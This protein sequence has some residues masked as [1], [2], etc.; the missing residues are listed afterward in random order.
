MLYPTRSSAATYER[1][2]P[3]LAR[4][5]HALSHEVADNGR[6]RVGF[7]PVS[8]WDIAGV[9]RVARQIRWIITAPRFLAYPPT[10]DFPPLPVL[11]GD[12]LWLEVAGNKLHVLRLPNEHETL[13]TGRHVADAEDRLE[14][15]QIEHESVSQQ[16]RDAHR[17]RRAT[18]ELNSRKKPLNADVTS[19]KARL[20]TLRRFQM[21]LSS[22]VA[23][24][25]NILRCPTCGKQADPRREFEGGP[26]HRFS[27]TC[28]ECS[29]TWGTVACPR[30]RGWIPT[31]L[32]ASRSWIGQ[33]RGPGWLDKFFGAD[34][35]AAP[36]VV[37]GEVGFVCQ[38]CGHPNHE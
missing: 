36:C 12:A 10:I 34:V 26:G 9:E 29:T 17:D 19:N 30:C 11:R 6:R 38:L 25:N 27:C 32:P 18:G 3:G 37:S 22:A 4:R 31:L 13:E 33:P 28:P 8:P 35:L 21:E 1:M 7:L 20:T 15:L 5:L 2:E 14:K 16:L 24:V 23:S